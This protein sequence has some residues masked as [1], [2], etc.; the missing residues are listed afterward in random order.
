MVETPDPAM[1]LGVSLNE[2]TLLYCGYSEFRRAVISQSGSELV[3]EIALRAAHATAGRNCVVEREVRIGGDIVDG[4]G[5]GAAAIGIARGG[6]ARPEPDHRRGEL[7]LAGARLVAG[8]VHVVEHPEQLQPMPRAQ[9]AQRRSGGAA[10]S[11]AWVK[12]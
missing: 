7:H 2:V 3:P 9:L 8:D 5:A 4:P 6:K 11:R 1:S 12:K 10:W